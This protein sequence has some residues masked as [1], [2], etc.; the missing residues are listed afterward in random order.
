M[1]DPVQA[2]IPVPLYPMSTI[3]IIKYIFECLL[4]IRPIK[5]Y[6]SRLLRS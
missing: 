5:Y 4:R 3:Y 2:D 6:L 1:T